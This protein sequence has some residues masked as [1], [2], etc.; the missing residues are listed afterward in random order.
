MSSKKTIACP[1]G[2]SGGH[3]GRQNE[4]T[5]AQIGRIDGAA[6]QRIDD[7]QGGLRCSYCGAVY[8]EGGRALG[9]L[10]DGILGPGW[11]PKRT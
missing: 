9:F 8:L 3:S 7:N 11:H 1:D 2:C 6:R 4:L 5:E 10:D